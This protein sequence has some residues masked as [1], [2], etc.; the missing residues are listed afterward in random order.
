MHTLFHTWLHIQSYVGNTPLHY[1]SMHGKAYSVKDPKGRKKNLKPATNSQLM[2]S[3]KVRV[4]TL[5]S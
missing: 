2:A 3:P 1:A 5:M 4:I